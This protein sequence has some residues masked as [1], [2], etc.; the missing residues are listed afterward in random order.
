M[1]SHIRSMAKAMTWRA[2]G[3]VVTFGV[4]WVITGSL[5]VSAGIGLLDTVLKVGAFYVHERIWNRVS[6]GK[7]KAPE[8]QI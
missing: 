3:T 6:F 1:E 7:Q 8:Y 4:A 5:S 2:G